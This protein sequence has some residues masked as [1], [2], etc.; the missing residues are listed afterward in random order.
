MEELK[1]YLEKRYAKET[2][3]A[4][5]REIGIYLSNCPGAE[6]ASYKEVFGYIGQLRNRYRNPKTIR[7]ILSVLKAYYDYLNVTGQRTDNPTAAIRLRDQ[8]NNDIQ[9]QDF[10]TPGELEQLLH[11]EERYALLAER[12][13]VL[14][15]LLIH[16]G[17]QPRELAELKIND[18]NLAD[19]TIY[20]KSQANTNSRTLS[21]KSNQILLFHHYQDEVRKQLLNGRGNDRLLIGLRGGTL[22]S[23]DIIKHVISHYK[24]LFHPRKVSCKSIRG[25]VITN[26]LKAGNE[27]RI[28]QMFAGHK[29]ISS[30][31]KYKQSEVEILHSMI[32]AQHPMK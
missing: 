21:L 5:Q 25:S 13:K 3:K 31:E 7:R 18:I 32:H 1:E 12:N 6:K 30:T 22:L 20:I 26:L 8:I 28:V 17:L 19:G 14:M 4:Y 10:F 15:S 24:G 29:K 16:Q 11:K 27:L 9:L 2:A 23:H